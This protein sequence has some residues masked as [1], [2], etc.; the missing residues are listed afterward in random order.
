MAFLRPVA[1]RVASKTP[2]APPLKRARNVAASSTVT[3]AVAP[4]TTASPPSS[5]PLGCLDD[6]TLGHERVHQAVHVLDQLTRDVLGEVDDVRTDVPERTRPGPFL[7]QS[8]AHRRER[9]GDPV[10]QVLRPHVPDLP[11]PSLGD[12]LSGEGDGRDA[13]VGEPD[14]GQHAVLGRSPCSGGHRLGLGHRVRQRLLAQHVLAGVEGR[15]RDLGVG[16]PGGADVDQVD[17]RTVEQPGPVGLG[18]LPA[19]PL[20]GLGHADRVTPAEHPHLGSERQVE[21][22]WGGAPALGVGR[23]HEGVADHADAEVWGDRVHAGVLW[24]SVRMVSG[25]PRGDRPGR[26]GPVGPVAQDLKQRSL[27]SSTLSLLTTGALST[28]RVGTSFWTRSDMPLSW[29]ISRASLM[30]SA[31]WV[32]G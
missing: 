24:S 21:E 32:G 22:T 15:D 29:A 27:Y 23:T 30:P 19:H 28:V 11:E 10:L 16:V 3:G 12:E 14:H 31:A 6:R 26:A 8:P 7:L 1:K 5:V 18:L 17:V 9:V 13:P 25:S 2:I 4:P 20:G